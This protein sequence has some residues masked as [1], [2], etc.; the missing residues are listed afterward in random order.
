MANENYESGKITIQYPDR[1]HEIEEWNEFQQEKKEIQD[2]YPSKPWQ[3]HMPKTSGRYNDPFEQDWWD[4]WCSYK[5]EIADLILK[6]NGNFS[7]FLYQIRP[8][9]GEAEMRIWMRGRYNTEKYN[10]KPNE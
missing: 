9:R 4:D 2:R 8:E 6:T 1:F 7:K 3:V 10:R 5:K